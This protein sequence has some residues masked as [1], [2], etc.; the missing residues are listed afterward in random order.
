MN[1]SLKIIHQRYK[2]NSNASNLNIEKNI[3]MNYSLNKIITKKKCG[4]YIIRKRF[5]SYK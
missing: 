4:Y 1:K 3:Y 2:S 5:F